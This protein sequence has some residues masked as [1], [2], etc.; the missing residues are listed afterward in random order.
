MVVWIPNYHLNTG[1]LN[2]RQVKVRY[3]DVSV[4]QMFVIQI[5]TVN[6]KYWKTQFQIHL[7]FGRPLFRSSLLKEKTALSSQNLSQILKCLSFLTWRIWSG[8]HSNLRSVTNMKTKRMRPVNCKYSLGLF[9]PKLGTPGK[10]D[11]PSTLDS[12]KTRSRAP[13][14]AKFLKRNCMSQRML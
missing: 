11:R 13:I 7:D 10:R 14:R 4:I 3:S 12:A 6:N 1:H 5:P 9:S 2:T 8:D